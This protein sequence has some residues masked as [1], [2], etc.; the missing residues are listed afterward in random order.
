MLYTRLLWGGRGAGGGLIHVLYTR[1]L[2]G[3]GGAGGAGGLIHKLYTRLLWGVRGRGGGAGGLIHVLYTRVYFS[4]SPTIQQSMLVV[5][6]KLF[7][8]DL[9]GSMSFL[10]SI[11]T[12]S[13]DNGLAFVLKSW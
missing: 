9:E 5:F 4:E 1:L 12:P 11:T 8:H 6:I 13:G 7:N 10:Q 2:W 3:G